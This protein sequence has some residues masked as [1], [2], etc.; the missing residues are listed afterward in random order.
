MRLSRIHAQHDGAIDVVVIE[1][2]HKKRRG[3]ASGGRLESQAFIGRVT[4]ESA[5]YDPHVLPLWPLPEEFLVQ[6]VEI[7]HLARTYTQAEV[8]S[9]DAHR[10]IH[11]R[12]Q[13]PVDRRFADLD[14]LDRAN[15]FA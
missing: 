6:S 1:Q 12:N 14:A 8:A 4:D 11:H 10:L 5:L 9:A 13:L 2:V 3:G 7:D 15:R